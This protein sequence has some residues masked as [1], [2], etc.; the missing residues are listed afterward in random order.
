MIR[1][2]ALC[3]LVVFAAACT[4]NDPGT[5]HDIASASARNQARADAAKT[6]ARHGDAQAAARVA[7]NRDAFASAPDH[8]DLVHYTNDAVHQR[9]AYTW[10]RTELSEA[11]ALHAIAQGMLHVSAPDGTIL[12]FQYDRIFEHASGDWT[13]IGHMV[14]KAGEQAIITFGE[15]AVFG[16]LAQ[17]G[18]LPLQLTVRDGVSWLI[19]TTPRKLAG[20][21]NVSARSSKPDFIIPPLS[22]PVT[23]PRVWAEG[24]SP[25]STAATAPASAAASTT[26]VDLVIGYTPGFRDWYGGTAAAATRLNYLVDFTSVAY[27]NS[28]INAQVRLVATLLVNG[29][30]TINSNNTALQELTGYSDGPTTPN[31][32]FNALRAARETY[33]ADLVSL[34]RKFHTPE[35]DGCGSAWLIGAGKQGIQ[36]GVGWEDFGYSVVSDGSDFDESNYDSYPIAS[37]RDEMLAHALGHNMGAA[38]DRATAM[39][40]DG[41]LDDPEDYGA[42]AYSFGYRTDANHGNFYTIMANGEAPQDGATPYRTFSTPLTTFCGGRACG[43]VNDDNA[44]T[45]RQTIPVV[46][47][48][49]AT[50]VPLQPGMDEDFNGDG[51]ADVLW[52][53]RITGA[54]VIWRSANIATPQYA[55]SATEAWVIVGTGDFNGDGK[56][57]ILWRNPYTGGN[58]IWKSGSS[59]TVQ[60]AGSASP[61]WR[62]VGVGD[63]DGDAKSDILWRE[64]STGRNVIW[65]SAHPLT[66]LQ[67]AVVSPAWFVVGVGDFD[68]DGRSDVLWRNMSTG[69]NMFWRYGNSAAQTTLTTS[70]DLNWKVTGVADFDADGNDDILWRHAGVGAN[71]IWKSGSYASRQA[72]AAAPLAWKVEAT[73]DYNGDGRADI[74]WRNASTG[75][76]TIWKSASR[77]T[78]QTVATVADVDWG[79]AP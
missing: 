6:L 52:R 4:G 59:A 47:T 19:E 31:P 64:Q 16:T 54:V 27:V 9:G 35:N 25:I 60:G 1:R 43:T 23:N 40:G 8:G 7:G 36:A 48:F 62:V 46:A 71:Q 58:T 49:R 28:G 21:S 42:Y 2:I 24:A 78:Q 45:L 57:D 75:A 79:I 13:W 68:G 74:L 73:G 33:G 77:D 76:D 44:R 69:A 70:A 67:I 72:L 12:D 26:T 39:D 50:M 55:G 41:V 51:K 63:F 22:A 18:K 65:K 34:V 20:M 17:P 11:H 30:T 56:A 37:C 29:Y 15:K 3:A 10:H 14:G 32:A 53:N 61:S 66:P 38:H 5:A